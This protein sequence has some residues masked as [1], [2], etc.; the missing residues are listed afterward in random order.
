MGPCLR[1]FIDYIKPFLVTREKSACVF[2]A[3]RFCFMITVP[4]VAKTVGFD[5]LISK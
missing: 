5:D 4:K 3:R 1:R 2:M